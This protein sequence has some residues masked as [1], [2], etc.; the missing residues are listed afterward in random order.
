MVLFTAAALAIGLAVVGYATLTRPAAPTDEIIGPAVTI[1]EGLADGNALG[2]ASAPVTV[3]IWSD[4]QCPGCMQLATRVEPALIG[5]YVVPGTARLVYRDAAFQG[6]RAGAAYD[7]S[8][9]PAAAARCAAQQGKFWTMHGWLF[10]NWNGENEGAFRAERLRAI[11]ES[12]GLDL[13]AYDTCMATGQHQAAVRAETALAP[14]MPSGMK[15][16]PTLV[17]NGQLF[18]GRASVAEIGAAIE[19]AAA[20]AGAATNRA[21]R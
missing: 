4:F 18:E 17:I 21:S 6:Q 15:V 10:A 19:A 14:A 20:D 7:E 1:P 13:A 8:V 3:E 2:S 9:E 12:A 5:Q 11:A 16:T